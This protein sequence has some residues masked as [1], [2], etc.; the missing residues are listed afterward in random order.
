MESK[1]ISELEQYTGS[2]DGFM[3]P[4]VADGE[5]QKANLG[6]LVE[7]KT[8]AA[9]FLK[10]SGLKTINGESIVGSGDLNVAVMNPLKG[11]FLDTDT[12]PT[13]GK[14]GD[15]I[16]VVNTSVTPRT[17]NVWSWN[18]TAF[19]DTGKSVEN[20]W[21]SFASGQP[22]NEVHIKDENGEEVTG[23]A[24]VLSAEAGKEIGDT[25]Y[26]ETRNYVGNVLVGYYY[27]SGTFATT[28]DRKC[29]DKIPV[30]E[31]DK[32]Y[33]KTYIRYLQY[34]NFMPYWNGNTYLG[35]LIET[36]DS[37]VTTETEYEHVFVI[38]SGVTHIAVGCCNVRQ[39]IVKKITYDCKYTPKEDVL[40]VIPK[41]TDTIEVNFDTET[42]QR[43]PRD[44]AGVP[45]TSNPANGR[46]SSFVPINENYKYYLK[47]KGNL[48]YQALVAYY[49]S[50]N[51]DG[52]G[53]IRFDDNFV[54]YT[55]TSSYHFVENYLSIPKGAKYI[56]LCSTEP[57]TC[58]LDVVEYTEAAS[59]ESLNDTND[60]LENKVD[61]IEGKGLSQND[62]T[63]HYK[64]I[65]DDWE[66][67]IYPTEVIE[68]AVNA[69]VAENDANLILKTEGVN[70]ITTRTV[71]VGADLFNDNLVSLGT[72][73]T[74]SDNG[75][76]HTAGN[77]APLTVDLTSLGLSVND[78]VII[79]ATISGITGESKECYLQYGTLPKA[80]MYNATNYHVYG[81]IYDGNNTLSFIPESVFDGTVSSIEIKK[82]DSS[83]TD[84]ILSDN[85]VLCNRERLVA[86]GNNLFIGAGGKTA[87][88]LVYGTRCVALGYQALNDLKTGNRNVALGT[89]ALANIT[90][91]EN[92]IAI[93]SD[94]VYLIRKATD[95]IGIGKGAL[96]HIAT[97]YEAINCIAIG[98]GTMSSR[99]FDISNNKVNCVVIGHNA[100]SKAVSCC[101]YVGHRAGGNT[102]DSS[103]NN[104]A[105][106]CMA[107]SNTYNPTSV[108]SA[109]SG[110]NNVC[111][112]YKASVD[113]NDVNAR[114]ASNSIALGANTMIKKSNQVVIGNS[115]VN[116]ILL[117]GGNSGSVVLILGTK[118]IVLND[119]YSVTWEEVSNE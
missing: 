65:L 106:G 102:N 36:P 32:I 56:R 41:H 64:S 8:E 40:E 78:K 83:G 9:G 77:T 84:V 67:D 1:K 97:G 68:E 29:T 103:D 69:Y 88:N 5:T 112:G 107:Y 61:K 73:W 28:V 104:V 27:G 116:E 87:S 45:T 70:V 20:F 47:I 38:P 99:G 118:K 89:F 110:S 71:K 80:K 54:D 92:N 72:G 119:D 108:G 82:E 18:G 39:P 15:Y 4:G 76:T 90:E 52:S 86:G 51:S 62:F 79:W 111:I 19:A 33:V 22:V 55:A 115:A 13:T 34:V 44:G 113:Y 114:A 2:A 11:T 58:K 23:T 66:G 98:S 7:Q 37:S 95:C 3:V 21:V 14:D 57:T 25:I 60:E 35:T 31:G 24:N 59:Q 30:E 109:I 48:G 16:L 49:T 74:Q 94:S 75:Y 26:T 10:P 105:I 117:G 6:T 85:N 50:N 12:L 101:T 93:G 53:F 100:G 63:D 96:N 91:G 43:L 46:V 42:V 81:F 17:A